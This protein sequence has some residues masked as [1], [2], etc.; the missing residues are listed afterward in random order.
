D[1]RAAEVRRRSRGELCVSDD[2]AERRLSGGSGYP[3]DVGRL[4]ADDT[5]RDRAREGVVLIDDRR[6]VR[7]LGDVTR[8]DHVVRGRADDVLRLVIDAQVD[9]RDE[10]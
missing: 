3:E 5:V 2:V 6:L 4:R 10:S 7:V 9:V 1:D 8:D